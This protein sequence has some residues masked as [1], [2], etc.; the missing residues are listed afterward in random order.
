MRSVFLALLLLR[1]SSLLAQSTISV[2]AV[3]VMQV[4]DD[5]HPEATGVCATPPHVMRKVD[6]VY[7]ERARQSRAEGIVILGLIVQKDGS[8]REIHPVTSP[9]ELLSQAAIEAVK[10]WRFDPP[11]YQGSAVDAQITVQVSF[12]LRAD[13]APQP[14]N[15]EA[16][17]T[18]TETK[19]LHTDGDEA[20][21]QNDFQTAAN[22]F[23]RIIDLTPQD[24]GA[25]NMLGR[26]LLSL[27]ELQAASDAFTNSIKFYPASPSAYNNLGL[28]YWRQHKYED[29]ATQFR[30]QIV[31]NPDDHYA[32]SNLGIM[33]RDQR[34][35]S[36]AIPELQKGLIL[37]P[38]K[39]DALIALGECDIDLGSR[40]KGTSELEQA[41]S[42]SS[43]PGTWNSAA[44][45]LA[46][47]NIE[48]DLAE[49]WSDTC[50]NMESAR[51]HSI[52][53]DHLTA[54]QLNFVTWI[55]AYWDTRGWIYFL[56]GDNANA[57]SFIE[58][59]WRLYPSTEV[60]GHLAQVYEKTGRREEAIR[61]YA[62]AVAAAGLSTRFKPRDEEVADA[63]QRLKSL[64]ANVDA[65]VE[66]A[67][68]DLEQVRTIAV[69][70]ASKVTGQ[71]DFLLRITNHKKIEVK[72]IS[73]DASLDPFT[74]SLQ[75]ASLPV[76]IP[77]NVD[78]EIPL[79]GTLTCKSAAEP[80]RLAIFSPDAAVDMARIEAGT[81]VQMADY[82]ST[83]PH[84][85]D[86]PGLGM[87]INLADEWKVSSE[88]R[89][90]FSRPHNVMFNKPGSL[91]FFMLTRE[92]VE[93]TPELYKKMLE[94][95]FA[96]ESQYQRTGEETVKR[97]G[98]SG[99]RWTATMTKNEIAYFF[100]TEFFTVGDDHYR[101]TALAPKDVYDRYAETFANMM[102]SVTFPMLHADPKILEGLNK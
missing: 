76:P 97:D 59:S 92:H 71:G 86:S 94:A 75:S 100:E 32:H 34:K 58:A 2:D 24:A 98:L 10:R 5:K 28:V 35:C 64:G 56:R 67:S 84:V 4:C 42:S 66:H 90:S 101:L 21:K 51:L 19:N 44:Y 22:I 30:K 61:T 52:S 7:P 11:T 68:V 43:A 49:K 88:D 13:N 74:R 38:N 18:W 33:L 60:G 95:G 72:R 85:Y 55:A 15:P 93:S 48:L 79:R 87:R 26:S 17:K 39:A 8:P 27:N 80:C 37:T 81:A 78:V 102:H 31:V 91:A 25:W 70:N 29:A 65:A 69:S 12:K 57:E 3:N 89:G 83:D 96:R 6:P 14:S 54:D 82:K 20:Y 45:A 41:T 46:R 62:M 77:H 99:T 9:N 23:R 50:L 36:D 16:E 53:L 1:C 63:R 47:R 40:A 73:G